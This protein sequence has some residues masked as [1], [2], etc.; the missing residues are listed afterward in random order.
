[1]KHSRQIGISLLEILVTI[2]ILS[3]LS[4]L[5]APNVQ[6]LIENNRIRAL[7][8]EFVS[9]LYQAR[10][11]SV[12]RGNPVTVCASNTAQTNCDNSAA[13][14]SGGWILFVDYDNDQRLDPVG[15]LFDTTG[16]GVNDSPEQILF[17]SGVPTGNIDIVASVSTYSNAVTYYSNGLLRGRN[18]FSFLLQDSSTSAQLAK[19]T[20]SITGR[21]RQCIGDASRCP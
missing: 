6:S 9:S 19:I 15:T 11:E 7:N 13:D 8:D 1:M 10:S 12:K 14:Y 21:L 17:V 4:A 18:G 3:I 16:D 2:S 5:A 20:V